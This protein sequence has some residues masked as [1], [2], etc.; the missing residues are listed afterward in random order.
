MY[1]PKVG[2]WAGYSAGPTRYRTHTCLPLRTPS[3]RQTMA[4]CETS[5][6]LM[7]RIPEL[8]KDFQPRNG[9]R[10]TSSATVG[11]TSLGLGF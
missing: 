11:V 6:G 8:E 10:K 4:V 5:V 9:G 3:Q 1:T 7:Q 2:S